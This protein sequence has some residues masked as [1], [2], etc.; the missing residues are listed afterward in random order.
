M[1]LLH[2]L[3]SVLELISRTIVSVLVAGIVVITILGIYYRF[4]LNDSLLWSVELSAFFNVWV[5]FLGAAIVM[6]YWQHTNVPTFV[7]LIPAPARYYVLTLVKLVPLGFLI[8]FLH[9]GVEYVRAPFHLISAS[10]DFNEVWVKYVIPVSAGFMI[11]FAI[12]V[13]VQDILAIRRNDAEHFERQGS[14]G[15][16]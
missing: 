3:V 5:G 7:N 15:V 1:N 4:V 14:L 8:V 11:V 16:E 12:N 9:L 2:R 6:R 10:M 13:I